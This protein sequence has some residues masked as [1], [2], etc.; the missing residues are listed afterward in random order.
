MVSAVYTSLQQIADN[1]RLS[2]ADFILVDRGLRIG[3]LDIQSGFFPRSSPRAQRRRH[4]PLLRGR[5][6]GVLISSAEPFD[7]M[8]QPGVLKIG[9]NLWISSA[10]RSAQ[11][12]SSGSDTPLYLVFTC[13]VLESEDHRPSH[14]W[15]NYR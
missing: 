8:I 12:L 5:A 6:K 1:I 7:C 15:A 2:Q 11:R 9:F 14:K 4:M 3:R 10:Y 13:M